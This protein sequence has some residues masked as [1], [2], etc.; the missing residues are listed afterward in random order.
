MLV[1]RVPNPATNSQC[2]I[3]SQM[4]LLDPKLASFITNPYHDDPHEMVYATFSIVHFVQEVLLAL[5]LPSTTSH[6]P[7]DLCFQVP[8]VLLF[9]ATHPSQYGPVPK[10]IAPVLPPKD[11]TIE[12]GSDSDTEHSE[13]GLRS[14]GVV[15][16]LTGDSKA[17]N[18]DDIEIVGVTIHSDYIDLMFSD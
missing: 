5:G 14:D 15:L 6:H 2:H 1:A 18:S 9:T 7:V 10:Q 16:D 3:A 13:R 11:I 4:V 8:R 17:D 12:I